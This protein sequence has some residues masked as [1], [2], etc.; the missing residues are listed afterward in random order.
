M[1]DFGVA[2]LVEEANLT[3]SGDIV[4][5]LRSHAPGAVSVVTR[6]HDD[7]YSLGITLYEML[8]RRPAF[9]YTTPQHLIQ[10]ITQADPAPLRKL[11]PTIPT[12]LENHHPR[13]RPLVIRPTA[14]RRRPTL[15]TTRAGSSTIGP[16]KARAVGPAGTSGAGAGVIAWSPG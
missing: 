6:M 2:K 8:A 15:P 7:V 12:D 10:L 3:A 13:R 11:D 4:G 16:I 14:I 1:T 5:T 9:P